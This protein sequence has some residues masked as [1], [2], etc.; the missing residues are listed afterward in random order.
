[1]TLAP[2]RH[3]SLPAGRW[4]E[5]PELADRSATTVVDFEGAP[6]AMLVAASAARWPGPIAIC[7][8]VG[9][10]V[11]SSLIARDLKTLSWLVELAGVVLLAEPDEALSHAALISALTTRDDVSMEN[12]AGKLAGAWNRPRPAQELTIWASA[13]RPDGEQMTLTSIYVGEMRADAHP[14]IITERSDHVAR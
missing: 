6:A 12:S 7:Q 13:D 1:V 14:A 5:G 4:R 3:F 10:D 2:A 11:A 9:G 8:T